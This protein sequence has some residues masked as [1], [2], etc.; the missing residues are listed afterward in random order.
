[1]L[2][3]L[4]AQSVSKIPS[5]E[6]AGCVEEVRNARELHEEEGPQQRPGNVLID[7]PG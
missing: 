6:E 1:M 5:L 2:W 3:L 4:V 7:T